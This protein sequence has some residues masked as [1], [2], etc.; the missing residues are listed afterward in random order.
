[1]TKH[2]EIL[3]ACVADGIGGFVQGEVASGY[4]NEEIGKWFYQ[5]AIPI[6]L[7]RHIGEWKKAKKLRKAGYRLFSAMNKELLDY[8][9]QKKIPIGTTVSVL[10]LWKRYFYI[11]HI[12]DSKIFGLYTRT[13]N[14]KG[15]KVVGRRR[16]SKNSQFIKQLTKD[17]SVDKKTLTKCMG[18]NE[19][20]QPDFVWRRIRKGT[21]FL[22]CSDGFVNQISLESIQQAIIGVKTQ[23]ERKKKKHRTEA[24]K[25]EREER[26]RKILQ[27][28]GSRAMARGET[29]NLSAI[30]IMQ[31]EKLHMR[32]KYES[33]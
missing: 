11:F 9:R 31:G 26:L 22:L 32:G 2:G 1:M 3:L 7:K 28:I 8:G 33:V 10:L 24:D 27:E 25:H 23:A 5:T 15:N 20:S 14:E 17:H 29:D 18:M 19:D 6:F 13:K 12:G 16:V 4:V 21:V 30:C